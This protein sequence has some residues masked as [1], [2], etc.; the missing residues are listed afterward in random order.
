MTQGLRCGTAA[1]DTGDFTNE[2]QHI[3]LSRAW[4]RILEAVQYVLVGRLVILVIRCPNGAHHGVRPVSP[5]VPT[6]KAA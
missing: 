3:L 5:D 6:G 2:V 4:K 1:E